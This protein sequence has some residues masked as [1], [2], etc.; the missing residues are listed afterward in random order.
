MQNVVYK[1]TPRL[2]NSYKVG[3]DGT[4]WSC[5]NRVGQH[6][7]A[8]TEKWWQKKPSKLPKGYLLVL[9]SNGK[10][11][12]CKQYYVHH[13]VLEAFIGPRLKNMICCHLNGDPSDNRVENLRWDT[14]EANEQDKKKHGTY[15]LNNRPKAKDQS[16]YA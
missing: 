1:K 2:S 15:W 4:I 9:I 16:Q 13:L 3:S 11:N 7:Y 8:K 6:Q 5:W 14:Y 10:R 12:S